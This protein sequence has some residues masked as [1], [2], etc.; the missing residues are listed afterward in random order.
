MIRLA[1]I[2]IPLTAVHSL[3]PL[4]VA[5][6]RAAEGGI[7]Q[8]AFTRSVSTESGQRVTFARKAAQVGDEV[9]QAVSIEMRMTMSMRQGD[10]LVGKS[11]NTVRTSQRR[12]ATTTEVEDGR[13]ISVKLQYPEATRLMRTGDAEG[14]SGEPTIVPQPVQGKTY[15]C[16][17]EPGEKNELVVTDAAGQRPPSEEYEIVAA[18]MQAVGRPNPLA[19]FLVGR[20]MSVGDKIELPNDVASQVFNLGDRF[21]KV[22]R[23]TLSL[24]KI[25]HGEGATYAVFHA[26]VEAA[27][28]AAAQMRLEVEGPFIVDVA[29]C[30]ARKIELAGPIGMSESR[31]TYSTAYQTIG[32]GR[33]QMSVASSYRDATR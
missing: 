18:Q 21:G 10:Q 16:R 31:G 1:A 6:Q 33:M 23:F 24:E 13:A 29:T 7:E 32:T 2:A 14:G 15:L 28:N 9:E 22:T 20:T 30:R 26:S 17:R 27:S 19:E 25:E 5:A 8:A 12:V 4:P 11:E 3:F